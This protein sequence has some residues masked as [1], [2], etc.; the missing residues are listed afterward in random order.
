VPEGLGL[1]PAHFGS[2]Q[3]GKIWRAIQELRSEGAPVDLVTVFEKLRGKVPASYLAALSQEVPRIDPANVRHYASTVKR[4]ALCRE[5]LATLQK[6]VRD[7]KSGGRSPGNVF[8]EVAAAAAF[9]LRAHRRA[10]PK[11]ES[12]AEL[13]GK[14]IPPPRWTVPGLVPEGITNLA[15]RPK[16]GKS[17]AALDV[18]LAVALGG[19]TLGRL[20]TVRGDVLYLALEISEGGLQELV[21]RYLEPEGIPWPAAFHYATAW[22]PLDQGGI[23]ELEAWLAE[24]PAARLVVVDT[25]AKIRRQ[26]RARGNAYVEDYAELGALQSLALKH[27]VA[28]LLVTHTS[29]RNLRDLEDPADAITAS[30]AITAV[31]DVNL[32]LTRVDAGRASA[33]LIASGRRIPRQ[34]L[35][36]DFDPSTLAW[37]ILGDAEEYQKSEARQEIVELLR[38]AERAM[39]PREIAQ[40]LGKKEAAVK[41]LLHKLCREGVLTKPSYGSYCVAKSGDSDDSGDSGDSGDWGDSRQALEVAALPSSRE[42]AG[43]DRARVTGDSGG[44][45]CGDSSEPANW[46]GV[47]LG[48]EEESL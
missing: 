21:R 2:A 38:E 20:D 30:T 36:L 4:A 37:T 18:A 10:A 35:A 13:Q 40:A 28:L 41:N 43:L 3:N 47:H 19:K 15:G 17:L 44:D 39:T 26:P 34:D 32:V 23:G 16:A 1:E 33:R 46:P 8:A 27:Q 48:V 45:S 22:K 14:V 25:L 5:S 9:A 24:R 7:L 42:L 31:A 11:T 6:A 29:K 12:L